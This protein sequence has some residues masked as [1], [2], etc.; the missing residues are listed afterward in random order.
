MAYRENGFSSP[1]WRVYSHQWSAGVV[2]S[3]RRRSLQ[4]ESEHS[5]AKRPIRDALVL[6]VHTSLCSASNCL[7]CDW[8]NS[9][10][11]VHLRR[12][13]QTNSRVCGSVD[14]HTWG[15]T[16]EGAQQES[17]L[18]SHTCG[19]TPERVTPERVTPKEPHL[20]HT[21]YLEAAVPRILVHAISF[22][23]VSSPNTASCFPE[24]SGMDRHKMA[25]VPQGSKKL[26][27]VTGIAS[28]RAL[29]GLKTP[30]HKAGLETGFLMLRTVPGTQVMV[31]PTHD[32]SCFSFLFTN[33]LL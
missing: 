22:W 3:C 21:Q 7:L 31:H 24:L 5:R 32:C 12:I 23:R 6:R 16:P 33:N 30:D 25:G 11:S 26:V 2:P 9:G 29:L 27:G 14:S 15:V 13:K 10:T 18:R 20:D 8:S 19:V 17:H 1:L 28:W 4:G